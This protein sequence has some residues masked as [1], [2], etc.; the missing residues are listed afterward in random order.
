MTFPPQQT[1]GT[2]AQ[3]R[4]ENAVRAGWAPVIPSFPTAL[5]EDALEPRFPHTPEMNGERA[6]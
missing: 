5:S 3:H 1:R 2:G 4:A 6:H